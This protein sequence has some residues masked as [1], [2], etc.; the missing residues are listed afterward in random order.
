MRRHKKRGPVRAKKVVYNGI[1]FAS[2]LEKY[3]YIALVDARTADGVGFH[4]AATTYLDEYEPIIA[5]EEELDHVVFSRSWHS[6]KHHSCSVF[7]NSG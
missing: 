5:A 6:R 1:Q 3:M 7:S 4:V 2:G